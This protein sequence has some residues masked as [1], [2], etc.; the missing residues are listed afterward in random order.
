MNT[1]YRILVHMYMYVHV[2]D[3]P[4]LSG[5]RKSSISLRI[6]INISIHFILHII[7]TFNTHAHVHVT[8]M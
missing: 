3:I 4:L 1:Q 7:E 6:Q 5:I 2:I 8:C